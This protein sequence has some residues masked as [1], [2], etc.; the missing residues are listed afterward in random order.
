MPLHTRSLRIC[1]QHR[2]AVGGGMTASWSGSERST[3]RPGRIT[4]LVKFL[5]RITACDHVWICTRQIAE[6]W[7]QVHPS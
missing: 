4:G 3:G 7:R 6:H 2:D 5:D 1:G